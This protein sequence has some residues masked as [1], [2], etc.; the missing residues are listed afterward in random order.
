MLSYENKC[1]RK[2]WLEGAGSVAGQG[3]LGARDSCWLLKLLLIFNISQSQCRQI[4]RRR[5]AVGRQEDL[6][7]L[8]HCS[9]DTSCC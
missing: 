6:C 4:K 7:L 3:M 8:S 1:T 5:M 2:E 9:E